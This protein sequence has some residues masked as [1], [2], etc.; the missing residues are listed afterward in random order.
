MSLW[1]R[2]KEALRPGKQVD[3]RTHV[4]VWLKELN[5]VA[6]TEVWLEEEPACS[7]REGH[8]LAWVYWGEPFL[9]G[10]TFRLVVTAHALQL[11]R[12][13]LLFLVAHEVA[14]AK[15]H[16]DYLKDGWLLPPDAEDA[17]DALAGYLL[18]AAGL[19]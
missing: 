18:R 17:A 13:R 16:G 19:A 7:P 2:L 14:H 9:Q 15:I 6:K 3:P 1:S 10:R 12:K 11:H 8:K 4:I 5:R